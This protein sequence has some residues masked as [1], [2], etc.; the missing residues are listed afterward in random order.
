MPRPRRRWRPNKK[1]VPWKAIRKH[2][3]TRLPSSLERK[4]YKWLDEEEI[5]Y[6][7]E[8]SIGKHMHVD[9][10]FEPKTC[11]ELNGCHWHG[12]LICNKELTKEQKIA[13]KKD[14]RR[15]YRIRKLGFDVVVFWECEVNDYPERVRQTLLL[16][17]GRN[18][19]EE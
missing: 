10:F 14:A 2:N 8:K 7:K 1:R 18:K 9:V 5:P 3:R 15:Y 17:A 6:T 16:L 11:I 13:Q 12:C 19:S 4:V